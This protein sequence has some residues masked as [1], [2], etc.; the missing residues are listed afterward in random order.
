MDLGI[1]GRVALVTGGDSGIGLATAQQLAAA[2]ARIIL[3]DVDEA[4]LQAAA[5]GIVGDVVAIAADLTD[6]KAVARLSEAAGRVDIL[7]H[8]AG[9][10]GPTGDFETLS[11]DDWRLA[12]D[13]DLMAAVRLLRAVLPG[14]AAGGWGRVVLLASEDAAQ[15]Y[16]D[17]LPYC[18]AKAAILNLAKGLSKAYARKGVLVNTVSPAF[19][20]TPMTD[21]MM[22]KRAK[23]MGC[24]VDEAVASFLQEERPTLELRRRGEPAEVAAAIAFLASSAASF[25]TGANLRVDGG[26]VASLAL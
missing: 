10:T 20:H 23:A 2:G 21:A 5:A 24:S 3:S 18:A 26:S 13:V 17:E 22:Q 7:V 6:P 4:K 9:I 16:A 8:A 15:P 1:T 14:M 11:D 25:V 19:I 12:L